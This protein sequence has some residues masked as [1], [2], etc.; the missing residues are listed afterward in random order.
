MIF[1]PS[2]QKWSF[3]YQLIPL[4]KHIS[5]MTIQNPTPNNLVSVNYMFCLPGSKRIKAFLFL[6][7]MA[8]SPDFALIIC[9]WTRCQ[10]E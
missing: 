2:S 10:V 9:V 6:V 1:M 5:H 4:A 7:F 8:V 3:L